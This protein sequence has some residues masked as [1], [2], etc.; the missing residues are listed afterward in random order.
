MIYSYELRNSQIMNLFLFYCKLTPNVSQ[1][2]AMNLVE[3]FH[4]VYAEW[5]NCCSY[6]IAY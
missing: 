5:E 2:D 4:K 1:S 3:M 6:F